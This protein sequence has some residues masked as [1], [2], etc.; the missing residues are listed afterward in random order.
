MNIRIPRKWL[1]SIIAT[2]GLLAA[3]LLVS[4]VLA[5]GPD[6]SEPEEGTEGGPGYARSFSYQGSLEEN[7]GPVNGSYDFIVNLYTAESGGTFVDSCYTLAGDP[8]DNWPVV[9]GI[10]SLHM[11]CGASNSDIFTGAN[12]R[13]IELQVRP[14]GGGSYTTLPRQ[15]ISTAP[16]AFTLIPGAVV[17][18]ALASPSAA[19]SV[20]Q[21][22]DASGGDAF[23]V[24]GY[25]PGTGIYGA[26]GVTGVEGFGL[27][28]GVYGYSGYH[29]VRGD[30]DGPTGAGVYGSGYNVGVYGVSTTYAGVRGETY[31]ATT[32]DYGVYGTGDGL[33][34]GVYGHQTDDVTGG[35]GVYGRNEGG[36]SGVSGYNAG[37]GNGTWGYS[38]QYNGVGGMT[39]NGD[40]N[41]GL[42]TQDN[43]YSLNFHILGA[44]MQV[45]QNGGG[46]PLERGDVVVIAGMG[47]PP[48]PG[49]PPIL[50]VRRA[51]AANSTGV[52]GVVYS[53]HAAEWLVETSD[54]TGG[55]TANEPIPQ[56]TAG[57][58]APGDY[59]LIVV[60]GPCQVKVDAGATALQPGDL[61]A[62]AGRAGY[63]SVTTPIPGTVLGKALEP[64]GAGREGL[65]YVY[66]TLE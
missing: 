30:S 55:S 26:G 18:G 35:L 33:A 20:T 40:N 11:I 50:Q 62:T 64:L 44:T 63:A 16:V 54:P 29:G 6:V 5:Q 7:G 28:R 2:L 57:P 32:G 37:A 10:F 66:V 47:D 53:T 24:Y 48:T 51:G 38:A 25:G 21:T 31:G 60:R 15:P 61:L 41:Y 36:G 17:H 34:Y 46:E 13:W 52:I 23:G 22:Y 45:A 4:T 9:D 59:L 56:S 1:L 12:E 43:L 27:N 58:V 8:F 39:G 49:D 3:V 42:Y 65:I 19:I 14:S